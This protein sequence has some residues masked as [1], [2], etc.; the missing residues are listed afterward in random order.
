MQFSDTLRPD[1]CE[2]WPQRIRRDLEARAETAMRNG[3]VGLMLAAIV[4]LGTGCNG[5][6]GGPLA[7]TAYDPQA[8]AIAAV[9]AQQ[10]KQAANAAG[11]TANPSGAIATTGSG[12]TTGSTG[13][14][15]GP[16]A[17]GSGP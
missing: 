2:T 9:K 6:K 10:A 8:A 3:S 17:A 4:A 14:A 15:T 7:G 16:T 1:F 11:G 12:S 5:A 13:S